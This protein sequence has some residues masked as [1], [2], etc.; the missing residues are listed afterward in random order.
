MEQ[1]PPTIHEQQLDELRTYNET[2]EQ[3]Y[4]PV[5]TGYKLDSEQGKR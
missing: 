2:M 1:M 5:N 4:Q 3:K